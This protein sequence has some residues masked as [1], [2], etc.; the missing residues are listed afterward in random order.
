LNASAAALGQKDFD[1]AVE[2]AEKAFELA[3]ATFDGVSMAKAL[4]RSGTAHLKAGRFAQAVADLERSQ[5]E[6]KTRDTA[7]KLL[8]ARKAQK[9]AER[10]AYI[11]PELASEAKTAGNKAF[12][13]GDFPAAVEHYTEA[14]KRDPS[15]PAF[16]TNRAWAYIKLGC[17]PDAVKD[18]DAALE[19][20]AELPK[21]YLR[22]AQAQRLMKQDHKALDTLEKGLAALPG[23]PALMQQLQQVMLAIQAQQSSGEAD[24]E[25]LEAAARDPEIQEILADPAFQ[26]ILQDMQ[27]DPKAAANHLRN[28]AIAAK[29]QK[30][31]AAGVL[32]TQ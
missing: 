19:I 11:N 3:A 10:V 5:L 9:E 8:E 22:K 27:T 6:K 26:T 29:I 25:R 32:R 2:L 30:L 1:A 31:V 4:N 7:N 13:D 18:C 23:N 28:P 20:S 12:Q 17:W 16:L 14:I 21:A 15:D 24:Q